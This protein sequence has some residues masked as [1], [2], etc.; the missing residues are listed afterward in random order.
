MIKTIKLIAFALSLSVLFI[1]GSCVGTDD[2]VERTSQMEE[3][4]LSQAI[5]NIEKAGYNV[6]TTALG[7]YYIMNKTGIGTFPV[8]G[9]TC[10]LIYTG[11]FLDGTIFDSSGDF[12]QD[13]IWQFKYKNISVIPGFDD[14]IA[15]L[16]NGAEADIIIPSKL[17]YG[18]TGLGVIPP[19]TPLV[20][21]MK[22]S[23]LKPV[24]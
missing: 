3:Q 2:L 23:G 4:E 6:D 17:A 12:A 14:G 9:D 20:F 15:L 22:M 18:S 1:L 13:S 5:A 19:Y 10:M 8:V 16:N 7:V 24:L 21:S 11:F